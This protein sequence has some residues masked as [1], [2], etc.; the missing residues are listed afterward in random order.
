M[1]LQ[2]LHAW[3]WRILE[4]LTINRGTFVGSGEKASADFVDEGLVEISHFRVSL[5]LLPS[6]ALNVTIVTFEFVHNMQRSAHSSCRRRLIAS[7][8][9]DLD[10]CNQCSNSV[11][12][13]KTNGTSVVIACTVMYVVLCL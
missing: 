9:L 10:N 1:L 5:R 4:N 12:G 7:N 13:W 8:V 11:R 6:R 2:Q 3:L